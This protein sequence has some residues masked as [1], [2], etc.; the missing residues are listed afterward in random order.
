MLPKAIAEQ[1]EELRYSSRLIHGLKPLVER[2]LMTETEA[3]KA[4]VVHLCREQ[5]RLVNELAYAEAI[6]PHVIRLDDG[7][8]HRWDAPDWAVEVRQ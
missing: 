8:I 3:L 2:G 5:E 4:A 6:A 1:Y 7:S